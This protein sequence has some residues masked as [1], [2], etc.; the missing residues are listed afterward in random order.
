MSLLG[1]IPEPPFDPLSWS[2]SSANFFAALREQDVLASAHEVLLGPIRGSFE[3]GRAFAVPLQLWKERYHSSVSRYTALTARA[4]KVIAAHPDIR[5][6]LQIGAWFS[7]G[8]TTQL[9]CFSYHD[10]NAALRY[11]H[12]GH[13]LLSDSRR[14]EHLSWERSVYAKLAGIFVMSRWLANSFVRDFDVPPYKV[15]VVGAGINMDSLPTLPERSWEVPRFLLV[16]KDFER[17]GGKYLLEAFDIVKKAL[18]DA[19][20]TIVGPELQIDMPGLHC[21]GYLTKA[22]PGDLIRLKE[23][24]RSATAVVLPSVYEPF[25][26]SLLEGMSYGLPC[27]ASDRCAMP[28]MVLHQDTGFIVPAQD[29][30]SLASAMIDL[31]KNPVAAARMGLAGR[32]RVESTFTWNIVASKIKSVLADEHGI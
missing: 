19:Q 7:S 11:R 30:R 9:P 2:G 28:E 13:G 32:R 3:M 6:V 26:I 22:D 17:K 14:R 29:S 15:H 5:G 10:G 31:A 24:F 25:G 1:L 18:P 20:L 23:F 4:G 21:P 16:G 27:I 8:S 12:Y